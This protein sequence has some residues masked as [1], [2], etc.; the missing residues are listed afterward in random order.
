MG[1]MA[2]QWCHFPLDSYRRVDTVRLNQIT[3]NQKRSQ[4]FEKWCKFSSHVTA[5]L[6]NKKL[7]KMIPPCNAKCTAAITALQCNED[8][9]VQQLQEWDDGMRLKLNLNIWK[10]KIKIPQRPWH[11]INGKKDLEFH[12]QRDCRTNPALTASSSKHSC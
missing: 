7:C 1:L 8:S 4:K 12:E 2:R 3:L 5:K 10:N 11:T 6:H 9:L